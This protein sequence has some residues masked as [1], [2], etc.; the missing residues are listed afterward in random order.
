[1]KILLVS[2]SHDPN[3]RSEKLAALSSDILSAMGV[4]NE[5]VR[6]KDFP[7]PPFGNVNIPSAEYYLP[8]HQLVAQADALIL[9]SPIYNWGCCAELKKFIEFIGSTPPDGSIKGA[10]FDK[11]LTF[12]NAAGLPHSYMAFGATALSLM[13]DFKCIINP[14]NVYVHDRHW[15]NE[16]A[17]VEEAE[18]R[19]RKS[20]LVTVELAR[21]LSSRSYRSGWEI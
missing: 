15:D 20:L 17:L 21:L 18:A 6:L 1:M 13:M 5:L 10:F 2:S 7:L 9:A 14:Y 3:S 4:S 11:I 19:L 12:I 16:G 8:L